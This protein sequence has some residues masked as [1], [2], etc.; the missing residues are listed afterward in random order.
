MIAP[1]DFTA[2]L[3]PAVLAGVLIGLERQ[4]RSRGAGLRTNTLVA[5][6]AAMFVLIA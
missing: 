5:I 1:G 6:G 4:S 3:G 2:R